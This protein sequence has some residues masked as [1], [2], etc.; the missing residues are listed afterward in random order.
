MTTTLHVIPVPWGMTAEESFEE[1]L[2]HGE[3][4]LGHRAPVDGLLDWAIVRVEDD[5]TWT[6]VDPDA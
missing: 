5:G 3:L 4:L 2:E 6:V 1:F